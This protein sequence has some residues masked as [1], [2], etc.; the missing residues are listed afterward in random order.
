VPIE[1]GKVEKNLKCEICGREATES[2]YCEFHMKAHENIVKK[3]EL[4]RKACETSWKEYLSKI[5]KSPFA[6]EWAKE[7]AE[8][9][10]KT[11]E[12]WN[13]KNS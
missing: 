5:V 3:Y 4:W 10:T 7:V 13:V 9:L 6:G 1:R 8:H 12:K 2:G 11:G